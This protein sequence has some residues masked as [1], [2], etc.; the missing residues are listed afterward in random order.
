MS[1]ICGAQGADINTNSHSTPGRQS[2]QAQAFPQPAYG[3]QVQW[4]KVTY[5]KAT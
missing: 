1:F 2:K 3:N 4:Q 5:T